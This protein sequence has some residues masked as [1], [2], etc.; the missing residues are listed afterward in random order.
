MWRMELAYTLLG[1]SV[2]VCLWLYLYWVKSD[3]GDVLPSM[4]S[5]GYLVFTN[6]AG[7]RASLVVRGQG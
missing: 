5:V 4:P 2:I 3:V 1:T 6:T 7:L